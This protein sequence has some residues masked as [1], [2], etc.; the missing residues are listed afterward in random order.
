MARYAI[1]KDGVAVNII[2]SDSADTANLIAV[3]QGATARLL[4][5]DENPPRPE[6]PIFRDP[7]LTKLQFL[8]RFTVQERLAIRASTNPIILDF[9]QLL[10]LAQDVRL[11]DPDTLIG[12]N[13]LE[14]QELL[15]KGRAVE[16]LTP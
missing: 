4:A 14:Q 13:Y 2:L 5:E 10:D 12:V 8:R 15:A 7:Q 16:I 9:M 1:E 11:D 3:Q 6:L